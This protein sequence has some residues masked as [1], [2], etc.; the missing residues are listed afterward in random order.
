[1]K[2][3]QL[4]V[5]FKQGRRLEPRG[6]ARKPGRGGKRGGRGEPLV[7]HNWKH[8]L[9]N[10]VESPELAADFRWRGWERL[11]P[12]GGGLGGEGGALRNEAEEESSLESPLFPQGSDRK[13]MALNPAF[14]VTLY[15]LIN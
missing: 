15:C 12:G 11:P 9:T 8:P 6:L 1:M 10:L 4:S 5:G 3:A 7:E 14:K 2:A 13:L